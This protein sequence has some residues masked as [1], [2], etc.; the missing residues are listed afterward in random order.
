MSSYAFNPQL[1]PLPQGEW[2]DAEYSADEA[3]LRAD[4]INQYHDILRQLGYTDDAGNYIPGTVDVEAN[5][6]RGELG[7]SMTEAELGVTRNA[8]REGTLFSGIRA[9]RTGEAQFPYRTDLSQLEEDVPKQLAGLYEQAGGLIN[10]YTLGRNQLLA[11]AAQ[12]YTP[13]AIADPVAA[14]VVA[15]VT[16]P[17]TA[18]A[19][20]TAIPAPKTVQRPYTGRN[21][22]ESGGIYW[23]DPDWRMS[24]P[25]SQ[26]PAMARGG[27]VDGPTDATIGE[28]GPEAVV[29]LKRG[30]AAAIAQH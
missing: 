6:R 8:Q 19:L 20:R 3:K 23:N 29:P 12:R 7:R 4:T 14:P 1:P 18:P 10:D 27:I 11:G 2:T 13:P 25:A 9:D 28:E 30:R 22:P 5:R 21:D 15:P 17:G 26:R 24:L 16:A